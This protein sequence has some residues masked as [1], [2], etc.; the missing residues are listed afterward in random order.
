MGCDLNALGAGR[1]V[2]PGRSIPGSQDEV[3]GRDVRMS[4]E[5]RERERD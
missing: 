1:G 2:A 4:L 3:Q 5:T